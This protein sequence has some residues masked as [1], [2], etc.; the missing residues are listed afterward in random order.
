MIAANY[1][2]KEVYVVHPNFRLRNEHKYIIAAD[3]EQDRGLTGVL[4]L[5]PVEGAVVSMFDGVRNCGDVADICTA[6]FPENS[7][8]SLQ[9]AQSLLQQILSCHCKPRGQASR[10]LLLRKS[11]LAPEDKG[12]IHQ[13][14][15]VDFIISPSACR[16]DDLKLS[17]PT[18]ILWLVTNQ[19][20]VRCQYCYMHKPSV[21]A[22]D[23]LPWGRVNELLH[24][25]HHSGTME[26]KL[27]GGDP[28]CYP[29]LFKFLDVLQDLGFPPIDI[30]TKSYVSPQMAARLAE[31]PA[32]RGIQF[33]IDSTVPEIADFIV[34]IPGF[35]QRTVES[36][37][38][39][40]AAGIC[41]VNTKTVITPYTLPT[42][43]KL[44][45]DMRS[46]GIESVILAT[47]CRSG[48]WH[49]DKLYNHPDDYQWL[50]AEIKKLK[51]QFPEDKINYQN[52]PPKL[53]CK[54]DKERASSWSKRSRC[55]AGR[56][57][58]TI[59]ANGKV[60][61][62]EQ[63]PERDEDCLG[64]LRVRSI[65]EVWEGE[66]MDRYL[67]HPPRER[68]AGTPCC[69]CEEF[70]QCQTVIGTCVRD[71]CIHYG[72]RWSPVPHCPKASPTRTS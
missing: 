27:S 41:R 8:N 2:E 51:E 33:S 22:E 66:L 48:Y 25:A 44:Y 54:T 62:C 49:K 70:D 52:G 60:V 11:E 37:R 28:L 26:I 32:L 56:E 29:Y 50:D 38:N 47:Y 46:M 9:D 5:A 13:Y 35:C 69:D 20:L 34:Q 71:S 15:T 18:S 59:C 6:F 30:P 17:F 31:H 24:E 7:K 3:F 10:P 43:P 67:L 40:M 21:P 63:M 39:V 19:C 57:H 14:Q 72:T 65:R 53:D 12:R 58:M 1:N 45:R 68:F 42:I 61:A 64:D 55:T 16:L 4:R 36:I 23:L